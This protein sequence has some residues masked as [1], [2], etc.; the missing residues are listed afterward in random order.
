MRK[1]IALASLL[2]IVACGGPAQTTHDPTTLPSSKPTVTPPPQVDLSPVP[3]PDSVVAVIHAAHVS[4]TADIVGEWARQPLE[5]D[6]PLGELVG[7]SIAKL[8]DLDG[9]ADMTIAAEDRGGR[10]EP[11]IRF[12]ISLG[13]KNFDSAKTALQSEYGLL[14]L[15]NGAFEISRTGAHRR[16][17]D[18][19]FRVCALAPS[20]AGGRIVCS[21]SATS[22]DAVLPYLTRGTA[23]F[24]TLKSDVHV[25]ARPGPFRELVRRERA[26]ITQDGARFMGGGRDLKAMWELGLADLADGFLDADKAFLDATIDAK[27]GS[28]DLKIT[29]KGSHALVTRILTAHPERA[30]PPPAAF[31]R[32][33]ADADIA[34][35]VHGLDAD[36]IATPK[37]ELAKALGAA[38]QAENKVKDPDRVAF[39][40]AASHTMD[41]LTLPVVYA[42]GV[43]Y[44]KAMPAVAGITEQ[45]DAA[46]IR[47]A[48]EQASGWDIIGVEGAPDKISAVFKEW[49]SVLA[50]ASIA[51]AMK[52]DGPTWK[53][54]GPSRGAPPGSVHLALRMPHDDID[55]SAIGGK[56]KPRAPIVLTLH[57]LIVP[58]GT[59]AWIVSALDEATAVTKAKAILAQSGTTLATR[60]GIDALK[61][62]RTNAGGFITPRGAGMGL[63]FTWLVVGSPRYRA[64]TDPLMGVSSQGQYTTPLSFMFTEAGTADSSSLT[65]SVRVPRALLPDVMAVGPRIFR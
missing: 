6:G 52:S 12:A 25:E 41:L 3:M 28:A 44:A 11:E 36:Q 50:R 1:S 54:A 48:I 57:T 22:R 51:A 2:G 33:P 29:A 65:F 23:A 37:S 19:D 46:K 64:A 16:D 61:A 32:L 18:S 40:D 47:V 14:P 60:E 15:G 49:T 13:V 30:E 59:R 38:L 43:D 7:E 10:R 42:R 55:Y 34:F 5:L 24:K 39:V 21:R 8:I 17:G 27:Q 9:P 31:L 45:S 62:S 26:T 53:L 63:P 20:E 58:D 4:A 56:P 35:F